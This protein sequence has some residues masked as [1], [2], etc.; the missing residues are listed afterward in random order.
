L[1]SNPPKTASF[2]FTELTIT[3]CSTELD[4][5]AL[6]LM[7]PVNMEITKSSITGRKAGTH[8]SDSNLNGEGGAIYYDS[9]LIEDSRAGKLQCDLNL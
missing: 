1:T 9:T 5:G 8:V 4:G 7:N 6:Y 3:E 2:S